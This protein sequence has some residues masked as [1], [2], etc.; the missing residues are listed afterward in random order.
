LH[1]DFKEAVNNNVM[2]ILCIPLVVFA[3]LGNQV[4]AFGKRAKVWEICYST[5]FKKVFLI[6]VLLFGLFRNI[7]YYPF[8][9]LAPASPAIH[10]THEK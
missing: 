9:L 4:K 10:V 7:S 6:V 8:F 2:A 1:G 5:L 3:E